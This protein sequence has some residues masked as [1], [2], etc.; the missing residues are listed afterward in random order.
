[1]TRRDTR[2]PAPTA[3]NP[4]TGPASAAPIGWPALAIPTALAC[5]WRGNQLLTILFAVELN[6]PSPV[7][8]M[9]RMTSRL[10]IPVAAAVRPQNI[11]QTVI[12]RVNTFFGPILSDA[13]PP[14][15]QNK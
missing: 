6:G 14:M 15:K 1:M 3:R 4:P 11:D 2:Q 10:T 12:A 5:S 8:K 13:Q 7:P 9:T